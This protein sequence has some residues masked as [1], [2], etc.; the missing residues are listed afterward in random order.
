M[1]TRRENS[2]NQPSEA[3]LEGRIEAISLMAKLALA[4]PANS[5]MAESDRWFLW[6]PVFV[7]A[8]IAIYFSLSFEPS[9][10]LVWG[11][12]VAAIAG[13]YMLRRQQGGGLAIFM[14]LLFCLALGLAV[15]TTRTALVAAPVLTSPWSGEL[16]GRLLASETDEKG[17]LSVTMGAPSGRSGVQR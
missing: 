9:L 8:G 4:V 10:W 13:L 1:S 14:A 5:F 7:G 6:S 12:L 2:A 3:S 17:A 16:T 11:L 15:A